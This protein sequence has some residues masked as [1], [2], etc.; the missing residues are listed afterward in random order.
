MFQFM[1]KLKTLIKYNIIK[2]NLLKLSICKNGN[3]ILCIHD[4][5]QKAP[6]TPI[7]NHLVLKTKVVLF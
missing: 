6:V 4:A 7:T 5:V 3:C 1:V 2:Q